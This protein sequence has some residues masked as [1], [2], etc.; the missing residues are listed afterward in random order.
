MAGM[1][2]AIIIT[3]SRHLFNSFEA[4]YKLLRYLS[5]KTNLYKLILFII[6]SQG[7][8]GT[9]GEKGDRVGL[10]FSLFMHLFIA[11]SRVLFTSLSSC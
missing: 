3:C 5:G 4:S 7:P 11:S 8:N 9:P 6:L 1:N 10:Y 2:V